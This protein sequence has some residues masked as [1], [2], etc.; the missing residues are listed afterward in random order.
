M[1]FNVHADS[2]SSEMDLDLMSTMAALGFSQFV[3]GP[4]HQAGHTLDLVFGV[5]VQVDLMA[6]DVVPWSDHY[7]LK[8]RLKVPPP[9][10]WAVGVF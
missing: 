5:G 6:T 10:A 7:A 4:T 9:P 8:A 1:D 2:P 3:T